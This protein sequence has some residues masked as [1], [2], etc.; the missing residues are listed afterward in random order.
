MDG[1]LSLVF[2][3]GLVGCMAL[4]VFQAIT[5]HRLRGQVEERERRLVN[6]ETGVHALLNC[7]RQMGDQIHRQQKQFRTLLHRQDQ[8]A[9]QENGSPPYHQVSDM[10]RI[11]ASKDDLITTCGLSDG[12]AELVA[13][14]SQSA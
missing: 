12:E 1:L 6:L 4:S 9:R 2:G 10:M 14:L 3:L 7:S 11:G 8:L 5:I 13:Y